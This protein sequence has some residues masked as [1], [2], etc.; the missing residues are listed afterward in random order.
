MSLDPISRIGCLSNPS[1]ELS[2]YLESIACDQSQIRML[3][4]KLA[5]EDLHLFMSLN[6]GHD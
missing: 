5:W 3:I 1:G 4:K 6:N 2:V